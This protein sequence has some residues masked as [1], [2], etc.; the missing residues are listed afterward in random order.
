[1]VAL[2][3][4]KKTPVTV[5][6]TPPSTGQG[7]RVEAPV[8]WLGDGSLRIQ[9]PGGERALL[10]PP[11]TPCPYGH[12]SDSV[13]EDPAKEAERTAIPFQYFVN[14]CA[15][16]VPELAAPLAANASQAEIRQRYR[17]TVE[18]MGRHLYAKPYWIPQL[19]AAVDVCEVALGKP[20]RMLGQRD[21]ELLTRVGD[22][23][24]RE[25]PSVAGIDSPYS[26]ART[27]DGSVGVLLM[28]RSRVVARLAVSDLR[29]R[30]QDKFCL[31]CVRP[32]DSSLSSPPPRPVSDEARGCADLFGER[33]PTQS[34]L[35]AGGNAPPASVT[36]PPSP[37]VMRFVRFA[38]Q[39]VAG[40]GMLDLERTKAELSLVEP[41]IH[42]LRQRS[43]S[44]NRVRAAVLWQLREQVKIRKLTPEQQ[45]Q[46]AQVEAQ[47]RELGTEPTAASFVA[48]RD[49]NLLQDALRRL[50]AWV[51]EQH[52]QLDEF[53]KAC[54]SRTRAARQS[55]VPCAKLEAYRAGL[56]QLGPRF[57]RLLS[58]D[59]GLI[60]A[61]PPDFRMEGPKLE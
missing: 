32:D 17:A 15:G 35:G 31:R 12:L 42:R 44:A 10:S 2:A 9:A 28:G 3:C 52:R 7:A 21:A 51:Q 33:P 6:E 61:M 59:A 41:V 27:E 18:C 5:V 19:L 49:L 57:F 11:L 55:P 22:E 46:I 40:S 4:A 54:A 14:R 29:R 16:L 30:N 45:R 39:A 8:R 13:S 56:G 20:W 34:S 58:G 48:E 38:A 25:L 43:S 60:D 24:E 23:L 26:Y 1:L 36:E 53:S 37:A 50:S 47:L